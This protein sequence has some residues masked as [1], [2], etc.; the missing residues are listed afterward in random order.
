MK[1]LRKGYSTSKLKVSGSVKAAG[2]IIIAVYLVFSVSTPCFA[3]SSSKYK[4]KVVVLVVDR[5]SPDDFPSTETPFCKE[6][7]ENWSFG[8]MVTRVAYD[9]SVS[10]SVGAAYLTLG[11]GV[12]ARGAATAGLS[13]AGAPPPGR[14]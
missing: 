2:V 6:L 7:A 13:D 4:N 11:A 12:R 8:M 9:T 10:E 14:R 1:Q 3:E 5:V